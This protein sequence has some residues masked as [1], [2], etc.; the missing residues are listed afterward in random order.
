LNFDC[1]LLGWYLDVDG[2]AVS[3]KDLDDSLLFVPVQNG[4]YKN[5]DVRDV[6]RKA[7]EWWKRQLESFE[8]Y[9]MINEHKK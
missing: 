5:E 8:T 4:P 1:D 6:I 2:I 3:M 7:I 9:Q